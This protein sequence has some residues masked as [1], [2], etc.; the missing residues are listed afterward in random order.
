M[1]D[2]VMQLMEEH[3]RLRRLF[4]QIPGLGG[5]QG[6]ADRATAICEM[7]RVHSILE[8]E[9]IYPTLRELDAD[10]ADQ[11]CA[12]HARGDEFVARIEARS[13]GEN[14]AR[15]YA[16]NGEVKA[17]LAGLEQE[18]ERHARWEE[19]LLFPKISALSDEKVHELGSRLY[20][21]NQE[22]LREF[23]GALE[24]S[25]ETEGFI[26]APRI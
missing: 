6:A 8:Q 12:D 19:D 2:P 14:D 21:R 18:F 3:N 24:T 7:Y 17:D 11:A 5:H 1:P 10:M 16:N 22:L 20:E 13:D 9:V 4:K 23:P 26:A 15:N 25:A